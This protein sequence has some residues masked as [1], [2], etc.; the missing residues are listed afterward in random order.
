MPGGATSRPD[1]KTGF[2]PHLVALNAVTNRL[3]D[4]AAAEPSKSQRVGEQNLKTRIEN[5]KTLYQKYKY[6]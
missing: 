1:G 3:G 2:N 4:S 6:L 5:S